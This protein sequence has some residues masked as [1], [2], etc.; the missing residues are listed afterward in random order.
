ML[1]PEPPT[2]LEDNRELVGPARGEYREELCRRP[3]APGVL[4]YQGAEV[5]GWAAVHRDGRTTFRP[6]DQDP[7]H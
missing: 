4:A 1:V 2:R 6:V 3:V 5:V 7:A